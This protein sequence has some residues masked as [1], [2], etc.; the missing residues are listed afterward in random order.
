M[1]KGERKQDT[2]RKGRRF[3]RIRA[4]AALMAVVMLLVQI[5]GA[6]PCERVSAEGDAADLRIVFT[7]DLHG[8]TTDVDYSKGV[9]F[10]KGGLTKAATLIKNA[11]N[12]VPEGNT[13]L[14]DL[15]DVMYDYTTDYIYETDESATQPIYMAMSKLNYDAIILG[16]HDYEYT[17]PYI[18]K[19]YESSGL[20]DKVIASNITDA[21]TGKHVFHEN[22]IIEKTLKT[23]NG[24]SVTIKVGVIGESIPTLSKKRCDYTG[25]LNGED[26]VANVRKE[27]KILKDAGADV[28]VVLAHSGVGSENPALMDENVGY[29]LTQIDGVDAVLCGHKH[30]YFCADGSTKYDK[31]PGVDKKT[32]LVNGKNLVMVANSGQGIGVIDLGISG[33]KTIV[34]RKSDIR[35]VK[36]NTA[37]DPDIEACMEKWGN[38]FAGD[39]TEVLCEL[40]SSARW[41]NYFGTIED[42]SPIQLLNDIAITYGLEYKNKDNTSYKDLPVVAASRYSKYGSGSGTDYY[43]IKDDLTSSDLYQLMNYRIG[44]W[45][46]KVTGAQLKE[47]LEWAASAYETAGEN[48]IPVTGSAISSPTPHPSSTATAAATVVPTGSAAASGQAVASEEISGH[49]M[50]GG[51]ENTLLRQASSDNRGIAQT[52]ELLDGIIHYKGSRPIQYSL[53][54]MYLTDLGLFYVLD[55]IEYEI[56]TSVAPRY[57]YNGKKINDT[58]RVTYVSRNGQEIKDTDEFLLIVNRLETTKVPEMFTT[59]DIGF[60]NAANTRE[61]FKKYLQKKSECGSLGNLADNNWRVKYSDKYFYVLKTGSGARDLVESRPWIKERLDSSE[62]FDYYRAD[63][64]EI[65]TTDKSGPDLNL[66]ALTQIET[67]HKVEVAVQATDSSGIGSLKY[68]YGKY[69]ADSNAWNGA[70]DVQDG[71]FECSKNGIYS[72]KA[73]DQKGNETVR[74]IRINNINDG[75]LEMPQVDTYTNR[76]T[77]ITGTAEPAVTIYFE[78]EDSTVY[79]TSVKGDGTF[80]YALPAQNAGKKVFVYVKDD[81]GRCSARNVITVKRTG[82]NKPVMEKVTT[83]VRTV[84]GELNDKNIYPVFILDSKKTVFMQDD[85]TEE[86]YKKSEIYNKDYKIQKI[87]MDITADGTYTFSLPYLLS[88]NTELAV[89]TLDVAAR[90][91][92]KTKRIVKQVVPAKPT[93]NPVTNLSKKVRVFSEEKCTSAVI[94]VG[95]KVY[96]VKS[97]TYISSKKMYRYQTTIPRTNSGV[98]VSAY[99]TNVKGKSPTIKTTKTEVVPDTPKVDKLKK[100]RK[101]ITGYVDVIGDDTNEEGATVRNT[102]TKVFVYVNGKKHTASIDFEGNYKVKLKKKLKPK[103]K[104]TVKARNKKGM[105]LAK[106]YVIKK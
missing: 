59:K 35:K 48:I 18:Q 20:K 64:T 8:Q 81:D 39:S 72:V 106:K 11:R 89:R 104:V 33:D 37:I 55:G 25:V 41:Q 103:D 73:V 77:Y 62:D 49:T 34:S 63:L 71:S 21:V 92:L 75:I 60:L 70:S 4:L 90:Q 2:N 13:L 98:K 24:Q 78:L 32:G 84:S 67:N 7:T 86:L 3:S 88:A 1:F 29:A 17:L 57:D 82:P 6:M 61:Y 95:K 52:S 100:G 45:R 15:G 94:K 19:Q 53:Q 38:V 56:D 99:L 83:A 23:S 85:G 102:K 105:G 66:A 79:K 12:E 54:E 30:S 43:D 96:T 69:N 26:M 36:T 9:L 93:M 47:W 50:S 101:K 42:S 5:V 10:A 14:F 16:N 80:K 22:K 46:Y 28:V 40:K 68:L 65:D 87:T 91:S 51:S 97:K 76:K 44:L 27:T 31:Y 74:Y 58:Q